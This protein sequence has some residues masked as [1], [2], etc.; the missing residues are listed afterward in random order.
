MRLALSIGCY[1]SQI[2]ENKYRIYWPAR[3]VELFGSSVD[4]LIARMLEIQNRG[5]DYEQEYRTTDGS[6]I[7]G[8]P[9]HGGDAYRDGVPAADCPYFEDSDDFSR[10]NT[11]WDEAADKEE[12]EEKNAI[13]KNRVGSVVTNRYRSHYTE[14]GHPT[15]C[16]DDLAN[17]LNNICQNKAG[18][19]LQLFESICAAN[20]I[21][22]SRY[23]RT[24]KGWQG[25]LRMT[26]RNLLAKRLIEKGGKLDMPEGWIPEYYQLGSDWVEHA[27]K[28]YKPKDKGN[29]REQTVRVR[30]GHGD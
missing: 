14:L 5:D 18:T 30:I 22:L 26:G 12:E 8:I 27:S 19:N 3:S 9:I 6:H 25:R 1:I 24:M 7:A 13:S 15:H 23:N 10:W 17:L 21:N 11:Q 4:D 20:G 16:G 29:E 2:E 28:K